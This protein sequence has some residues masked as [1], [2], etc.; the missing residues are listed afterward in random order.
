MATYAVLEPPLAD[1]NEA[2]EQAL[3]LRDGFFV[4]A[5]LFPVLWLLWHRLWIEALA[6]L[7]L[8]VTGAALAQLA[9]Q[10]L[11]G[12]ALA[13]LANLYFGLEAGNLRIRAFVRRG[14]HF[15]GIVDAASPAEAEL[16][17]VGARDTEAE[18]ETAHVAN[19]QPGGGNAA[20]PHP[21]SPGML[22]LVGYRGTR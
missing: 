21:S 12:T 11:L 17:Y 6:A 1:G 19:P 16:R 22:G 4:L 3:L 15:R 5:F 10:P 14:W 13:L 8:M 7:A 9:G 18:V 2:A 20:A